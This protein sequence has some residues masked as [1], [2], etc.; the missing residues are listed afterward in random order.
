MILDSLLVNIELVS[1]VVFLE[2]YKVIFSGYK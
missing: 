2:D 1:E